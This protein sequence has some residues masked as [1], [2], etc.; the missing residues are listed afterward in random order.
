MNC[1]RETLLIKDQRRHK[2]SLDEGLLED[3][4]ISLRVDA[5]SVVRLQNSRFVDLVRFDASFHG[6]EDA[7][8]VHF[9][10]RCPPCLVEN[11]L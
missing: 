7:G 8:S 1:P 5:P 11:E 2:L 10:S 9:R 3:F 4:R 6:P